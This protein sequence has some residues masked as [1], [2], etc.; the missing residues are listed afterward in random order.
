[1]FKKIFIIT[2]FIAYISE[3]I[4]F[5]YNNYNNYN[6]YKTSFLSIKKSPLQ[7]KMVNN[8][9][10]DYLNKYTSFLNKEQGE[11]LVKQVSGLF[12]KMDIISHYVL[13]TNDVL[14][15]YVLNNNYLTMENKKSLA[16]FLIEITQ[17][18]DSTGSHILQIY[19][20]LVN[21]LL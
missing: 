20:D 13:H 21:C 14:I 4:G 17:K 9:C 19:H 7:I 11:F 15:N 2:L 18:G 12:P 10:P 8:I 3:C 1:M 16:L 6:N 5:N